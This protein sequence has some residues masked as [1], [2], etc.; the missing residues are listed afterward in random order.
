MTSFYGSTCANYGKGALNT[1]AGAGAGATRALGVAPARAGP[2]ARSWRPGR[3]GWW[4]ERRILGPMWPAPGPGT[5][6]SATSAPANQ[7]GGVEGTSERGQEG[8]QRG[9]R[10]GPHGVHKGV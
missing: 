9:S 8:F 6:R 5:P 1:N 7:R 2:P 4:R 10:G 3:W